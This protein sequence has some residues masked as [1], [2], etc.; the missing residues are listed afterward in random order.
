MPTSGLT[1]IIA[2]RKGKAYPYSRPADVGHNP[3]VVASISLPNSC[4]CVTADLV[5]DGGS[6]GLGFPRLLRP[7]SP[8]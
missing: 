5:R 3:P 4:H 8:V 1:S 2:G 6:A 7:A